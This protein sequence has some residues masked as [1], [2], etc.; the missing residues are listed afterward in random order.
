MTDVEKETI[1]V[2]LRQFEH[3]PGVNS[4]DWYK[5][6]DNLLVLAVFTIIFAKENYLPLIFTSIIRP[7]IKGVSKT[8]IHS[9]GGA[10]DIF[11]NGWSK[12]I[13]KKFVDKINKEYKIGAISMTD[14]ME[15]EAVYEGPEFKDAKLS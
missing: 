10:F 5:V 13:I 8:D 12:E 7:K 15:R 4:G 9:K 2:T 3:K 1:I 14:G 6:H 11:T